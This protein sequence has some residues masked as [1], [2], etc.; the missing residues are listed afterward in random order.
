[1]AED[2]VEQSLKALG[3]LSPYVTEFVSTH[4]KAQPALFGVVD[5]L[6]AIGQ[7]QL[8]RGADEGIKVSSMSALNIAVRLF[9]RTMSNFQ[10]SVI[11]IE[12][13]MA[14][15]AQTLIRNCYENGFWIGA[16]LSNPTEALEA[17]KL[18]EAK[19]QDS[20]AGAFVRIVEKHGDDE[21]KAATQQQLSGR[22][23]KVK[24]TPLSVEK[25]AQLAGLYPNFA[26]Y[27]KMSADAAHASLNSIDQYLNVDAE[28]NWQD[29][30]VLGPVSEKQIGETLI[31]ACH[32]LI[33]AL[34]AFGQLIG[35]SENDQALFDLNERH[36]LLAG[37]LPSSP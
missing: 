36:K 2:E 27:K 29:G 6:N 17:F 1:M 7:R 19:S 31:L 28:G 25:V 21:L 10:G 4:R 35:P 33:S 22:R 37:I 5:D 14:V 32:A 20:R 16:L 18:D 11:L 12:R 9:I 23:A 13:G 24:E 15:E 26:F 8:L 34:A 3:F 30:F